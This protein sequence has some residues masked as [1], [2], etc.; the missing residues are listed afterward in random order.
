MG[1]AIGDYDND[2]DWDISYSSI[3]EHILMQNINTASQPVYNSVAQSAGVNINSGYGWGTLLFDV[4]ND[5][6]ED[7]Y[8]ATTGGGADP[9]SNYMFQNNQNG[10]FTDVTTTS[11][12]TDTNPTEGAAWI[13]FNLDGKLDI[14]IGR[15][16]LTYQLLQNTTTDNN[17]WV[18]FKLLAGANVNRDAIGTKVI[19]SDS[20]G[21]TQMREL[22]AGESRGS[23]HHKT[24]HF[25][26]GNSTILT[27]E[28]IWPGGYT[29]TINNVGMNQYTELVYPIYD[30]IFKAQFE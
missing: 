30:H 13:D 15:F 6:W 8:L 3:D 5:G 4:N 17:N 9:V 20:S 14:V 22:R 19:I 23:N 27:T 2:S 21:N 18:G 24:L 1:V 11:G 25:G 29:H 10:T 26:L 28:V 16:N 7:M 12:V